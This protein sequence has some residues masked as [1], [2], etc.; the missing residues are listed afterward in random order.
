MLGKVAIVSSVL[1]VVCLTLTGADVQSDV[2]AKIAAQ[3][4]QT[5]AANAQIK[6]NLANIPGG[7]SVSCNSETGCT[8][9]TSTGAVVQP[10]VVVPVA[11]GTVAPV[12]NGNQAA[13]VVTVKSAVTPAPPS[14][15]ASSLFVISSAVMMVVS[16]GFTRFLL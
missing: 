1:V 8:N 4:A 3:N 12:V 6:S 2:A 15:S 11:A 10:V 9:S 5:Q 7:I 16:A 13:A 14:G